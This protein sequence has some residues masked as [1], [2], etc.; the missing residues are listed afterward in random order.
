MPPTKQPAKPITDPYAVLGV[1]R[2]A[3]ESA[4][5][6]AYFRLVREYPPESAP[7]KFQE[8]RAAYEQLRT[9]ERRAQTDLFL[10]QEPPATPDRRSPSYDLSVHPEDIVQIALELGLARFP[11]QDEF[12]EPELPN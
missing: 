4:I 2:R 9:S 8:V 7:E 10:L 3:E 6:R 1:E 12:N 11:F 5:K